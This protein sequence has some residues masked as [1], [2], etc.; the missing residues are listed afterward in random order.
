VVTATIAAQ[1][2]GLAG[3]SAVMAGLYHSLVL[4]GSPLQPSASPVALGTVRTGSAISRPITITAP[5]AAT[6]TS[7]SV[8]GASAGMFS[9]TAPPLPLALPAGGSLTFTLTGVMA[10]AGS[11]DAA[12]TVAS[13]GP[14]VP[15]PLVIPI[16][17]LV[18]D[19]AWTVA[20]PSVTFPTTVVG[21]L[22]ATSDVTVTNAGSVPIA[23]TSVLL[24]GTNPGDFTAA[25]GCPATLGVGASCAV[26]VAFA[27]RFGASRSASL[28]VVTDAGT[29]SVALSGSALQP[30]DLSTTVTAAPATALAGAVITGTVS[31]V[32]GGPKAAKG[33]TTVISLS[34]NGTMTSATGTGWVCSIAANVATCTRPALA[35]LA[36]AK[37]AVKATFTAN[38]ASTLTATTTTSITADPDLSDNTGSATVKIT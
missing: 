34:A 28:Q 32:D 38:P 20:P 10:V 12:L 5:T 16:T 11:I 14:A 18:S 21:D 7:L 1:A 30:A 19:A 6:I 22:S 17:G 29:K 25:S 13:V 15:T 2:T 35:V 9:L 23:I 4:R 26:A 3:V 33:I 27:P 8:G 24:R 37:I 36:I 31:V